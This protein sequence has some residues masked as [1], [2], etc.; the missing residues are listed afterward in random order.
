MT[1]E[2]AP[3]VRRRPGDPRRDLRAA[4]HRDHARRRRRDARGLAVRPGRPLHRRGCARAHRAQHAGALPRR[5]RAGG[6]RRSDGAAI[7]WPGRREPGS[8]T[9]RCVELVLRWAARLHEIGLDVAHSGYHRHGAY[10]LA[11]ADMPGFPREE[12]QLLA[13]MVGSHRRK[14]G[15]RGGGRADAAMGQARAVPDDCCCGSRCCCI[16]A[17]AASRCRT[18]S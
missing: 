6:A 7:S 5:S 4:R 10:L 1:E 9:I 14:L 13:V 8:W 3:V 15:D 17:A 2:R 18:S 12:Q 16:A 11:N